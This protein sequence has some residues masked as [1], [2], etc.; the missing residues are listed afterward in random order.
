MKKRK[1]QNL[2]F[3]YPDYQRWQ[4]VRDYDQKLNQ[5][6]FDYIQKFDNEF[7]N[8]NFKD[9]KLKTLNTV[10]KIPSLFNNNLEFSK[11]YLNQIMKDSEEWDE[12]KFKFINQEK[13]QYVYDFSNQEFKRYC[14]NRKKQEEKDVYYSQTRGFYHT[15]VEFRQE[16]QDENYRMNHSNTS[17]QAIE[18]EIIDDLDGYSDLQKDLIYYLKENKIIDFLNKYLIYC[19]DLI[20]NIRLLNNI[21]NL[22]N[23]YSSKK[24]KKFT[25]LGYLKIINN[26]LNEVDNYEIKEI[27][28]NINLIFENHIYAK[29][30]KYIKECI[31]KGEFYE[32]N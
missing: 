9:F 6:E 30:N 1:L 8:G 26:I 3:Y 27:T 5:D 12:F 23:L 18:N 31:K 7:Y 19:C 24:M 29:K 14:W 21:R 13:Y 2:G 4:L 10:R 25:Y 28:N 16:K 11:N 17:M 20:D 32:S 15:S 22:E